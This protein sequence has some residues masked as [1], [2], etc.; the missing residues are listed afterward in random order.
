MTQLN[1]SAGHQ[2]DLAPPPNGGGRPRLARGG[3][4]GCALLALIWLVPA[5]LL[6]AVVRDDTPNDVTLPNGAVLEYVECWF[7]APETRDI[8]CAELRSRDGIHTVPVVVL[9]STGSGR[10][11]DAVIFIP[12]GPGQAGGVDEESVA[13]WSEWMEQL[14]W[15][16]DLVIYDPRGTGS[17]RPRPACQEERAAIRDYY[18]DPPTSLADEVVRYHAGLEACRQ[19]LQADGAP[20]AAYNTAG[21]ADDVVDLMAALEPTEWNLYGVSHGSRVALEVMRRDPPGLRSAILDSVLPSD[22]DQLMNGPS[23]TYEALQGLFSYCE[24]DVYCV[25]RY[26]R[27][28]RSFEVSLQRARERPRDL[29]VYLPGRIQPSQIRLDDQS[30]FA[31]YAGSFYTWEGIATLPGLITTAAAGNLDLLQPDFEATIQADLDPTFSW[32]VFYSAACHDAPR[33]A[34]HTDFVSELSQYPSVKPYFEHNWELDPCRVWDSGRVDEAF[35]EPVR[36]DVPA[37]VVAGDLDPITPAEWARQAAAHLSASQTFVFPGVGHDVI[38]NDGCA[39]ELARAFLDAPDEQAEA[40]CFGQL[41]GAY[42][43]YSTWYQ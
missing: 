3:R 2:P 14:D 6:V 23:A 40:H 5:V 29:S 20:I 8:L 21:F 16:R 39:V 33:A 27:L 9:E 15:R 34:T 32:P 36:S 13:F 42:F 12:G 41:G 43:D 4:L 18:L 31:M 11:G 37:L 28:R 35:F 7:R 22:A 25:A 38:G 24:R 17:S 19:R 30:L 26:P 1:A 10:Q